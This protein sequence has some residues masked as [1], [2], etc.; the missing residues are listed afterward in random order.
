[1]DNV[2]N[3]SPGKR[4]GIFLGTFDPFHLG[5]KECIQV[6]VQQKQLDLMCA[7]PINPFDKPNASRY[8][9]RWQT[10]DL[11]LAG[12]P[13]FYRFPLAAYER[14]KSFP[15]LYDCAAAIN[16]YFGDNNEYFFTVSQEAFEN[17]FTRQLNAADIEKFAEITLFARPGFPLNGHALTIGRPVIHYQSKYGGVSS[18]QIRRL[19]ARGKNAGPLLDPTVYEY[20]RVHGLYKEVSKQGAADV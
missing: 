5:H 9:H 14:F 2:I 17:Y 12:V 16:D 4:I 7:V 6:L 3:D 1:M 20:V 8:E 15:S 18:S 13:E 19:I 11:G 10:V